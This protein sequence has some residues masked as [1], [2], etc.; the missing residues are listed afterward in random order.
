[1]RVAGYYF[2]YRPRLEFLYHSIEFNPKKIE[3]QTKKLNELLKLDWQ[4]QH[5]YQTES[6]IVVELVRHLK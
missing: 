2:G 3:E 4:F 5:Q 6:G 1:M